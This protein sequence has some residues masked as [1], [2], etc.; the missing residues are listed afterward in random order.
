M[1]N[2]QEQFLSTLKK[3]EK[4]Y[5]LRSLSP[6]SGQVGVFAKFSNAVDLHLFLDKFSRE[7][8]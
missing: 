5:R 6:H 4:Q 7:N 8:A 3:F 1:A 2:E